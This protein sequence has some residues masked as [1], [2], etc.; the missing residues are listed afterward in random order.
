[1]MT[2]TS[3]VDGPAM[4]LLA[5]NVGRPPPDPGGHPRMALEDAQEAVELAQGDGAMKVILS[6]DLVPAGA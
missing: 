4:E 2:S 3:S 5:R 1:V 6:P